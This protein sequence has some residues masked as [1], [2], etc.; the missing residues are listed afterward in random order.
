[1]HYFR[2]YAEN[3]AGSDWADSTISFTTDTLT[4][5]AVIVSPATDIAN[6]TATLHGKVTD[7]GGESPSVTFYYGEN[8]AEEFAGSWDN[9]VSVGT[10]TSTFSTDIVD[11]TIGT[12]YYYRAFAD[13]SAGSD[14]SDVTSF[15]TTNTIQI[16]F[17]AV[18]GGKNNDVTFSWSHLLGGG[19][20]RVVVVGV[21]IEEGGV[22]ISS[23]TFDDEPMTLA[24]GSTQVESNNITA[25]FY[26]LDTDL[27]TEAGTY[28]VEVTTDTGDSI[29]A[30]AVSLEN[31]KQ[32]PPEAVT[33]TT[34][35]SNVSYISQGITTVTNGAWII[36]VAGTGATD[37][38]TPDSPQ[39]IRYWYEPSSSAVAGS[40]RVVP[41]AGMV[42]NGWTTS[43]D[44]RM[45]L[46]MAAFAP[47][48]P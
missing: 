32:E 4:A 18:S 13:N 21:G 24:P 10:E 33:G 36:D 47:V 26:I 30:G 35:G 19:D 17:D 27:P 3:S 16:V 5:P 28:T 45:C 11:L 43:G 29:G 1:M 8:D 44:R 31:V 37:L 23:V 22:V 2:A 9:S 6:T 39:V 38:L 14:W 34:V 20:D 41:T 25:I 12:T 15:A 42:V 46:S 40:T 7:T 48:D